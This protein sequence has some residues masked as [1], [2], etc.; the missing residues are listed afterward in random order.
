MEKPLFL[1]GLAVYNLRLLIIRILI[2]TV[3]KLSNA[4]MMIK[5]ILWKKYF[6]SGEGKE[7]YVV[8]FNGC[9]LHT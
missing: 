7:R 8:I 1:Y 9:N 5:V 4:N 2:L 3:S 6:Y